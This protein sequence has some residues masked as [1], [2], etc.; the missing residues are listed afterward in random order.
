MN[1]RKL[2]ISLGVLIVT[3]FAV[4]IY[5][6][7]ELDY[8]M[9][10]IP[11][12]VVTPDGTVL[13][14]GQDIRDG[15]NVWQSAGGQPMGSVWGHGAYVAPDWS[16]DWLHRE[17]VWLLDHWATRQ[18]GKPYQ[19]IPGTD[20]VAL[21]E[22]LREELRTN[23]YNP[24]TGRLVVS[25]NRAAAIRAVASHYI[26]LFSDAPE[27]AKLLE[28]YALPANVLRDP[29]RRHK[30]TAFFFWA[31]WACAANRPGTPSATPRTGRPNLWWAMCRPVRACCGRW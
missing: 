5:F 13:F 10:P 4:L 19:E 11:S 2:W 8:Q 26:Q 7:R 12:K 15:Q 3:S 28:A 1:Y 27:L 20:R 9:P 22:K 21:R 16:A 14:T 18:F 17:A 25:S 29:E 6:G 24:E 30:I 23:T 31:A